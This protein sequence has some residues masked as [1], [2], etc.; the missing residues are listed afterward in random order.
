MGYPD[1]IEKAQR[2]LR[3]FAGY[4]GEIDGRAGRL[5]LKAAARI[6]PGARPGWEAGRRAIGAA[7]ILLMQHGPE[8]PGPIDGLW[9][10]QTEAAYLLWTRARAGNAWARPDA[11]RLETA[12][13]ARWP[14]EADLRAWFG[15]PGSA[16]CTAGRVVAPWR[17]V[18]AWDEA[19]EIEGFRCHA[20]VAGSLQR[21]LESIAD[22][23]TEAEI[24]DLGLHLFGGC[25]N[26]RRKRGGT[27]WSTHAWGIACDFDPVRNRLHWDRTRARLARPDAAA[28]WSAVEAESW[29]GLGP[30]RN[31]DFM[32]IQAADL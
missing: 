29:T 10:P 18:L 20:D 32:H 31:F 25:F 30:E 21:I 5:T 23:Y 22:S 9:G 15:E 28:F 4:E 6:A 3:Q 17:M 16:A 12:R 2:V 27:A 8:L 26:A 7:Q 14:A 1:A 24:V 11:P 13:G 19:T